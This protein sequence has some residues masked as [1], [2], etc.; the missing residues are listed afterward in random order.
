MLLR[1]I[2]LR[3]LGICLPVW[4]LELNGTGLRAEGF[5]FRGSGLSIVTKL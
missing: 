4:G 1:C 2:G 3:L 5:Q